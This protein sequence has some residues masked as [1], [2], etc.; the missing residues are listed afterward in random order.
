MENNQINVSHLKSWPRKAIK[1]TASSDKSAR[2]WKTFGISIV[3]F[4]GRVLFVSI[5]CYALGA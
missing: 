1:R 2:D 5:E 4:L 3:I